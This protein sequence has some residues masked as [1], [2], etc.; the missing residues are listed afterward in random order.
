MKQMIIGAAFLSI[1]SGGA[2]ADEIITNTQ[3]ASPGQ[4]VDQRT[5][6]VNG[7]VDTQRNVIRNDGN[8]C[9]TKTQQNSNNAGDSA[10]HS[11][12]NC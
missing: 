7:H 6:D 4:K 5:V 8:G 3:T 11:Q 9:V 10:T 2:F 12:T 1:L